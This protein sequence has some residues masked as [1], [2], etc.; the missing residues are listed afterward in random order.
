M[1][2]KGNRSRLK[3]HSERGHYDRETIHRILDQGRICHVSFSL[4]GQPYIIPMAYA[5]RGDNLILHGSP[6]SRL[7]KEI[8]GGIPVCVA[9]TH[10]D[11]LVL[12]RSTFHHSL[13][14]RSMVAFGCARPITDLQEKHQALIDL[15]EHLTPGRCAVA[16]AA[17]D[18]EVEATSVV[19]FQIEE[20]S[21]KSR[22]GPP[23]DN[24]KDLDREVWAGVI[25]LQI[26]AGQPEPAPDLKPGILAEKTLRQWPG[27]T[28]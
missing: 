8:A 1:Y 22:S 7:L 3:R 11:G 5:R 14:F 12:A 15:T 20:A 10:L 4:Q 28:P 25:P 24:P 9:V 16:R 23:K 13:N 18:A 27:T 21:A 17:S 2:N 19:L 26:E 6:H